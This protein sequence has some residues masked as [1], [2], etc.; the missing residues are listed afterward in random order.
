[1]LVKHNN[2]IAETHNT[3]DIIESATGTVE[4]V[5]HIDTLSKY[6]NLWLNMNVIFK[7]GSTVPHTVRIKKQ[8]KTQTKFFH[9]LM[10]QS[11]KLFK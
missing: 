3:Y 4:G 2:Y 9:T 7:A 10:G 6:N 11:K 5:E 1:M 8:N